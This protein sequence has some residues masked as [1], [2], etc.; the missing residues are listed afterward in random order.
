MLEFIQWFVD[1]ACVGAAVSY[2]IGNAID[3]LTM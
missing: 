1:I 2:F 3:R